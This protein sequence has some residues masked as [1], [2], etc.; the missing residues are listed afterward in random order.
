MGKLVCW[1]GKSVLSSESN[2]EWILHVFGAFLVFTGV[3]M[4]WAANKKSN[5]KKNPFS[6]GLEAI[7]P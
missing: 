4:A 1:S 6:A 2:I 7:F 5:V 3:K